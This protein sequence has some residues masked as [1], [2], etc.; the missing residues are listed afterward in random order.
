VTEAPEYWY[1][2]TAGAAIVVI[3]AGVFSLVLLGIL[4]A[5]ALELRRGIVALTNKVQSIADRVDSVAK[6]VD[7]VTTEVGSR[8]SGIARTVDDIAVT[9]FEVVERYAP[10]AI[11]IAVLFKLRSMFGK[12]KP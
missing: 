5:V 9:A 12:K 3:I 7:E 10:L 1:Q 6:K 2:L 4:M 11:G 8:A